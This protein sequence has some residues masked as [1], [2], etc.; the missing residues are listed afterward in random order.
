MV[1]DFGLLKSNVKDVIDSFDHAYSMW[2]RETDEYKNFMKKHSERWIEMPVSP[3][4]EMY[5][6]MFY[7]IIHNIIHKTVW[8]NGEKNVL[9]H[10][11]R[12]HETATGWAESFYADYDEIWQGNYDLSDIKI[13]DG[14]KNEWADPKMWDNILDLNY[15][16]V[17]PVVELKYQK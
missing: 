6:L 7:A 1:V 14:I 5:S 8:N 2:D 4:A 13:S 16:F 12:V 9:L 17:N 10:S 11:V 15:T 3:S